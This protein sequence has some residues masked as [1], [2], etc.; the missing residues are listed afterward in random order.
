[1]VG[2]GQGGAVG[3]LW[4]ETT[5]A[6]HGAGSGGISDRCETHRPLAGVGG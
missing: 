2:V 3:M 6:W 5:L 1:M 4:A